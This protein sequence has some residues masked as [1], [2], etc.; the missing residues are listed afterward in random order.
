MR[1]TFRYLLA[2]PPVPGSTVELPPSDAH[3][4]V[5][6]VRRREG[7]ELEMID[8]DGRIWPAVV[9]AVGERSAA[10]RL[11]D[12]PLQGPPP[13]PVVLYQGLA[14]WNRLDT[15]VEKCAELGV[16]R[17]VMV[18]ADRVRRTP[19]PDAWR[20]RRER[21]LRVA[22]SA[23]RQSGQTHLPQ[24]DGLM[25]LDAVLRDTADMDRFVLDPTGEV[26]FTDALA[27]R[28]DP[29]A[30]VA[31]VVGPDAGW[32]RAELE[33][34]RAAGVPVCRMGASVLRAETAG[35]VAVV[36]ALATTGHLSR[37]VSDP[38]APSSS[39]SGDLA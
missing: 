26:A 8:A 32:S 23:A 24:V 29:A 3:H 19:Q 21:M 22:E 35:L 31:V 13:A 33:R 15:V 4:L 16:R 12:A 36:A 20:R 7:D 2:A 9:A 14:E 5:R 17:L 30:P 27:D 34:V 38:P 6:V 1:H 11:A 25:D 37:S 10:V 39:R 18:T 28:A